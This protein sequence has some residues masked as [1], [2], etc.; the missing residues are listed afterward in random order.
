M[1][2]FPR[3]AMNRLTTPGTFVDRRANTATK[4]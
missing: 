1:I 3:R 4:Q 2:G